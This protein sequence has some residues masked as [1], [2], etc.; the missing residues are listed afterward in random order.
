MVK[1]YATVLA[2]GMA[3][4]IGWIILRSLAQNLG[5]P[6]RIDPEARFGLTGRRVVASL[7]GF[8][9][10]GMSAEFSPRNP[11]WQVALVLAGAGAVAAAW[12]A[13]RVGT[14]DEAG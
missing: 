9:M 11:S 12:Y 1:V 10:A 3:A 8:G 13:G 14:G 7:V 6:S 5:S 2:V 4:L